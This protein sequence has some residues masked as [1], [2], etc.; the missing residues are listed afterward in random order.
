MGKPYIIADL[1]VNYYDTAAVEAITP[2]AAALRYID[3]AKAAGIDAVKFQAYRADTLAAKASPA[4]WDTTKEPAKTQHELFSRYEGFGRAEY[5]TLSNYCGAIGIDFMCT[6]FD[7]E[8]ADYLKDLMQ[9][10][11]ISSSDLSNLPFIRH[12]AKKGKPI[13]L[14]VGA[15]NLSEVEEAVRVMTEEDCPEITLLH[16]VLS[17]P[18]HRE[19]ANLNIIRT[20]K[21]VFPDLKVGYSDHTEPDE[22]M[23]VLMTAYLLGAEVIEKHF[24]LDK[25]LRGNDHYHAG[26]PKD[27][28]KAIE[29]IQLI[30]TMVGSGEKTVLPCEKRARK[31][32]RRSLV[33][34]RDVRAGEVLKAEDLLSKRPGTGIAPKF[35]PL[36]VGRTVKEALSE[37]T[38][39]SWDCI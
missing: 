16:C 34:T 25:S 15:S 13:Y 12:I 7:R 35:L 23:T 8:S 26:D 33:L 38:V 18:C 37:D 17:Y 36:V 30:Q 11:K 9:I 5:E 2:L 6:P 1:G 19:D 32:A 27:F 39:L 28:Q 14:S 4:Y 3:A 29:T 31:E 24:T 21:R 20:L 22:S 10:Y